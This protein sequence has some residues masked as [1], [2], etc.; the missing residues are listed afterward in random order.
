MSDTRK[1]RIGRFELR[2]ELGRGFHGRV[3]LAWDTQL[4]R[5]VALKLLLTASGDK[6]SRE[7]FMAEARA[8]ARLAH[9]NVIPLYDAGIHGNIP[10]L[11]FEFVE[12]EPLKATIRREGPLPWAQAAEKFRQILDGIAA[13]HAEQVAHL[14]L[15]PNNLLVDAQGR[16][17]VMDFGL[18]RLVG[19]PVDEDEDEIHGTPRY[20]SPE[21]FRGGPLDLQTDVFALGLVFYELLVGRPAVP[22]EGLNGVR[23]AITTGSF[24]WA[25]LGDL[26]VPAEIVAVLRDALALDKTTRFRDAADVAR[27][28]DEALR[29]RARPAGHDIAVQ[30]LLRRLQRRPEFPAFSNS[31]VEIN[32][33]TAEDSKVGI[34][35]LAAVVQ[36]DF[37]LTNRLMKIANSAFFDRAGGGVTTV[38]QAIS[39][40]GTRL[41]RMLCNGLLVFDH[42]QRGRPALED[43]LVCS[44]VA[45]LMARHFGQRMRRE[46][47]EE[48]FIGA[49]F[50]RLGRNL[51]LYYLEDEYQ[52]VQRLVAAGLPSLQAEQR[53]LATSYA[54]VG[55]AV[56][57][58][59]KFPSPLIASMA[60]LQAGVGAAPESAADALHAYAHLAN[61][62]CEA[63]NLEAVDPTAALAALARRFR[64]VFKGAPDVLGELLAASLEKFTELAPTLGIDVARNGFCRRAADFCRKAAEQAAA[65][66]A[67]TAAAE[68]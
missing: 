55:A 43:A 31:I 64:G 18:A 14:D 13:A 56:A 46:L 67:A 2:A 60:P 59:W 30:F 10:Y 36:R 50:N 17:R 44:F 62:L 63:A 47:A 25:P 48:A 42:M 11:V 12:G 16:V 7:Q 6:A 23:N 24:D 66:S 34:S 45:G 1:P 49:L 15:S 52:E 21:H 32:R 54:A 51:V 4:E 38:S 3:Y 27:A 68:A 61:E 41:V 5:K 39:L 9:P 29:L 33:L 58:S 8:V 35:E 20:M 19:R 37:S 65:A 26:D 22:A 40:V 57:A 53:V 28:L